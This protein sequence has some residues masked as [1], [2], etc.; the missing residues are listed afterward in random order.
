MLLISSWMIAQN[1]EETDT[2]TFRLG[3]KN[4]IIV[5]D[6]TQDTLEI[7]RERDFYSHWSSIGLGINSYF[8]SDFETTLPSDAEFM[9]LNVGKSWEVSLNLF[10]FDLGIVKDFVGLNS[11]LGLRMNN[12]RFNN[13]TILQPTYL[14][15]GDSLQYSYDMVNNYKKNKLA[16]YSVVMPLM[17]NFHIPLKKDNHHLIFAAG[18]EGGVRIH[19]FTKLK[20]RD[21]NGKEKIKMTDDYNL[22]PYFYGFTARV[23]TDEFMLYAHYDVTPLFEENK[24]PELYPFSFGLIIP[25][26]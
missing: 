17:I 5:D 18:V 6:E 24:G 12:Y 4:I 25:F 2:T 7:K 1:E 9:E 19:T 21:D 11:G 10:N 26:D 23:G 20:M 16:S 22:S 14:S 8:A 15:P 13:N 3:K